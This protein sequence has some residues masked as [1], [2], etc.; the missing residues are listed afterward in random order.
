MQTS[1]A[2]SW[3][4]SPIAAGADRT[5]IDVSI[6]D[7]KPPGA[8]V[9]YASPEVLRSLKLQFEGAADDEEGVMVNG[10]LADMWALA[11]ILYEMLTGEKPFMPNDEQVKTAQQAPATVLKFL[12]RQWQLYDVFAEAQRSWVGFRLSLPTFDACLCNFGSNIV[13]FG[14]VGGHGVQLPMPLPFWW[15]SVFCRPQRYIVGLAFMH[16][17]TSPGGYLLSGQAALSLIGITNHSVHMVAVGE[18]TSRVGCG[19]P[20]GASI[21]GQT[22]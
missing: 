19:G 10:C 21:A 15:Y 1:V 5:M 9:P 11:C 17:Q 2:L 18:C 16:G 12:Q 14:Q 6:K 3:E 7:M 8:T 20:S 13:Q 22:W 4:E